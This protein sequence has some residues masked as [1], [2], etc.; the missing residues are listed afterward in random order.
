M[1]VAAYQMDV[2]FGQ[3]ADNLAN[4][5]SHLCRAVAQQIDLAVFPECTLSGYCY[6]S[7]EEAMS[8]AVELSG[9]EVGELISAARSSQLHAVVGLL[10]RDGSGLYNSQVLIGPGGLIGSYRKI[11]LPALGVDRFVDRGNRPPEVYCAGGAK[12]GLAICYDS[13][14]PEQSRVM[15]LQGAEIIALSTNWPAAAHRVA[16]H[17]PPC[18]SL[19]NHLFFIAANRVGEERGFRF[20]GLSSIYGPDAIEYARASGDEETV[21]IADIDP[22]QAR[23]KRIERTPGKHVVDLF[24]DRRPEFYGRIVAIATQNDDSKK[25]P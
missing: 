11:H 4:V 19:E 7:R 13:S 24:A 1:R 6:E 12:I 8:A 23:N 22:A 9:A 25:L 18:R 10:E 2:A 3:L 14:F 21:L 20:C 17:V 16:R 5:T 15:A